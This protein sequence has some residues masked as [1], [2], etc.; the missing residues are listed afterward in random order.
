MAEP[1][2][3]GIPD[4]SHRTAEDDTRA[5]LRDRQFWIHFVIQ[6]L[7]TFVLTP[8]PSDV[9]PWNGIPSMLS[10][11]V[12]APLA[13]VALYGGIAVAFV[14]LLVQR[15]RFGL[16]LRMAAF[17]ALM[18]ALSGE[19]VFPI[20]FVFVCYEAV[21]ISLHAGHRRWL[22]FTALLAGSY[23][24][25]AYNVVVNH[26]L[27]PVLDAA[28]GPWWETL[29]TPT[30]LVVTVIIAVFIAASISAWWQFGASR[31]RQAMRIE[32]LR[33]RA[34][35]AALTE[36]NRIAREMHDVVAHSLTV[37]IAQ[38]DGGRFA[39]KEN[40]QV[41]LDALTTIS[42]VGRDALGQMRGLLSLLHD[43]SNGPGSRALEKLPG[44]DS[45]ARLIDESEGSG[46]K[47]TRR[48][49]GEPRVLE[50]SKGL[51]VFRVVQE[52]LTNALKHA[53]KTEVEVAFDWGV[54]RSKWLV[55]T[56]SNAAGRAMVEQ[57]GD[58]AGRGLEG[59]RQRAGLHGGT[60]SW[61]M[62]DASRLWRV[63]MEIPL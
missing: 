41:A 40:P 23:G 24:A 25:V 22:G 1:Q 42:S 62:D 45:V 44:L 60:A 6:S 53:G 9:W 30:S 59:I 38:A 11:P 13:Q 28:P 19:M 34:E 32:S 39:G 61:G 29:S 48:D 49:V 4:D 58:G 17:G 10:G 33:A 55:L 57:S 52:C 43:D 50:D 26:L 21:Q 35:L 20:G 27:K 36:R 7:V 54:E 2:R 18:V 46:L 12:L 31:R 14:G 51:T 47:V 63:R 37:V 3:G 15:Y 8:R 16:G 5:F 56:V